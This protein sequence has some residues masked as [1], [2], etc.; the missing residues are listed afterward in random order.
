MPRGRSNNEHEADPRTNKMEAVRRAMEALGYEAQPLD[1]QKYIKDNFGLDM[2]PN[3][4]S[5]YKSSLRKKAGM[6]G[7]RKKRGR[8]RKTEAPAAHAV[9]VSHD[10]VPWKDLRTIKDI[11]GRIGKRGLRELVELLD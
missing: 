7:R 8:P 6:K 5:S 9:A 2:N 3:M 1:I 10:A 11:A 4:I